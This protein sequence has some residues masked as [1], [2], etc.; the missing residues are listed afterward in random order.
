ME[1]III[2]IVLGVAPV[3]A[4][5]FLAAARLAFARPGSVRQLSRIDL[6]GM[7]IITFGLATALSLTR[8]VIRSNEEMNVLYAVCFLP[9]LLPMIWLARY[10]AQDVW[11]VSAS[12]NKQEN[13]RP[14]LSFLSDDKHRINGGQAGGLSTGKKIGNFP[15]PRRGVVKMPVQIITHTISGKRVT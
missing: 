1:I 13:S 12:K 11:E 9:F 8:Y 14:D 15:R 5:I 3:V 6:Q 4:A 7:F 10:A 2:T